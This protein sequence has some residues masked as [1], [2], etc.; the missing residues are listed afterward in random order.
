MGA[1]GSGDG[2][3]GGCGLR[4][5]REQAGATEPEPRLGTVD[6]VVE[7]VTLV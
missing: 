2:A 3:G 1:G 6:A 7:T 5:P 4:T